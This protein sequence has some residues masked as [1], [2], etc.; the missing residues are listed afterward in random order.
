MENET[1]LLHSNGVKG[2]I[3]Y[4]NLLN[5]IKYT[6]KNFLSNKDYGSVKKDIIISFA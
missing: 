5:L 3:K 1:F 6:K 4:F 2:R